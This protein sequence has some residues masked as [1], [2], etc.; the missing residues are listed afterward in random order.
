MTKAGRPRR[1]DLDDSLKKAMLVFC[2]KG[3]EGTTMS[4]L[5]ES[6]GMK[7]PSIYGA[8]GNKDSLFNKTVELYLELLEKGPLKKLNEVDDIENA[9]E[10][11]LE[12]EVSLFL[13]LGM[14]SGCLIMTA[15]INCAPEHHEHVVHLK[16]LRQLYKSALEKRFSRAL[17]ENQI[18]KDA[19]PDRLAEFYL[20]FVHGLALRAKDGASKLDLLAS[21]RFASTVLKPLLTM[22]NEH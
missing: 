11:M 16:Q 1:Y 19:K 18:I 17:V 3:Y 14:A 9:L 10:K 12:E 6:L 22:N 7:A 5:I 2:S 15:A 13:S 21:C 20:T 8:F 4:D